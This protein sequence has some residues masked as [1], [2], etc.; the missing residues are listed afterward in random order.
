[1][2][3]K[4]DSDDQRLWWLNTRDVIPLR[5]DVKKPEAIVKAKRKPMENVDKPLIPV[6]KPQAAPPPTPFQQ[7]RRSAL[8]KQEIEAEIDLHG[9]SLHQAWEALGSFFA[10]SQTHGSRTVLVITGKGSLHSD[11]TLRVQVPRWF[12]EDPL[13]KYVLGYQQALQRDGGAGAYYVYLRKK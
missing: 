2:K 5:E 11:Q 7:K 12:R 13:A 4:I 3:K 8:R 10:R 6:R 9:M 1:M